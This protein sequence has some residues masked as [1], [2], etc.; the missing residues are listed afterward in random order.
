MKISN[1][2]LVTFINTTNGM[3]NKTLPLKLSFALKRNRQL[4]DDAVKPYNEEIAKIAQTYKDDIQKA[5]ELVNQLL[6][7]YINL[8]IKTVTMDVIDKTE[9]DGFDALTLGELEA[10]DFM[11]ED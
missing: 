11:I 1:K 10:I 2:Q 9:E 8:E 3:V 7:E 6:K 4:A 5:N